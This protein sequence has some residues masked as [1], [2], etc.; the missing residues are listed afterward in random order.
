MP[1]RAEGEYSRGCSEDGEGQGALA[2]DIPPRDGKSCCRVLPPSS[3]PDLPQHPSRSSGKGVSGGVRGVT[4]ARS[5]ESVPAGL[6]PP[7]CRDPSS[8]PGSLPLGTWVSRG[9]LLHPAKPE[10]RWD[11]SPSPFLPPAGGFLWDSCQ[12]WEL[13]A[14]S[15][16]TPWLPPVASNLS[17]G[18]RQCSGEQADDLQREDSAPL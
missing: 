14:H 13:G 17:E 12:N 8:S 10:G 4:L 9:G 7:G 16:L 15:P 18:P 5:W 3:S 1:L 2:Q 11:F 6:H